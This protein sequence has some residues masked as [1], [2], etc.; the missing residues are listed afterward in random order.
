MENRDERYYSIV[1][2]GVKESMSSIV[3]EGKKK[4]SQL[5][6]AKTKQK[7]NQLSELTATL[8]ASLETLKQHRLYCN[9]CTVS[10]SPTEC[11]LIEKH[12][13]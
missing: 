2:A 3:L 6:K 8:C 11:L 5:R 4:N 7:K 12:V 9:T 10:L 1:G 13:S